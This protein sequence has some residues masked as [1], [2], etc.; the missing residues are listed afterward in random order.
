[1]KF[2]SKKKTSS[3]RFAYQRASRG[4]SLIEV[5]TAL[6][7]LGLIC[8]SV[9]VVLE[10]SMDSAAESVIRT[11]AFEIARD[12]MELLLASVKVE[13]MTEFG[14]SEKY[15]D[16]QWETKVE[17]FY[18]PLTNRLWVQGVC[19]AEYED[20]A[21]ELQRIELTSWLTGLTKQQLLE[22]M[23]EKQKEKDRLK[24]ADQLVETIEEAAEYTGVDEEVIE[25]WVDNG[26]PVTD[27]GDFIKE[28]LDLYKDF[29]GNPPLEAELEV[30]KRY[31]AFTG[32]AAPKTSAPGPEIDPTIDPE[33]D[34]EIDTETD[35]ETDPTEQ[36][37]CGYTAAELMAMSFGD[38]INAW[39]S[40]H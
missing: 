30:K 29:D 20:M 18:E 25:E 3:K 32:A 11:R 37:Y 28:Y 7:I 4:F 22:L 12:K 14:Y 36:L 21:G 8:S 31:A 38:M 24:M 40:C 1:M 10:R 15:P 19:S 34:P 23:K 33:V 2:G 16:I 9:L 17:T 13:E 5:V 35:T 39:N 26:M 27:E 6:A